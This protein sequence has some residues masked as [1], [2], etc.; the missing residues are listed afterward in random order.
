[1]IN[2]YRLEGNKP[3][4]TFKGSFDNGI[5]KIYGKEFE[6]KTEEEVIKEFNR[7]YWRCVEV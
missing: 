1:M 6:I 2:I 7:G 3:E 4:L 5:L